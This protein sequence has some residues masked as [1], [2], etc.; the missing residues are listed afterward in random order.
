MMVYTFQGSD[1]NDSLILTNYR[2]VH[3]KEGC[4]RH[5]TH[6]SL[7]SIELKLLRNSQLTF[8]FI[9]VP[10]NGVSSSFSYFEILAIRF[11]LAFY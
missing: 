2:A 9:E 7:G 11:K 6:P 5:W 8:Y 1:V 3:T 10:F 4:I